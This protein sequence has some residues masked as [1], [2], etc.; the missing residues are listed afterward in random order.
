MA[1]NWYYAGFT[2]YQ[3]NF[4][5]EMSLNRNQLNFSAGICGGQVPCFRPA[6]T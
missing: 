2:G 1:R 4:Y 5:N 6:V 3:N